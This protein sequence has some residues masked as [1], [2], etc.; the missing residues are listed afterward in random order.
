MT[1]QN[2]KDIIVF[3]DGG[4]WLNS[5]FEEAKNEENV[6]LGQDCF[7][8][9]W[10]TKYSRYVCHFF[11]GYRMQ[12]KFANS[13]I[14]RRLL[15]KMCKKIHKRYPQGAICL[16]NRT[17]YLA[18]NEY[19][20]KEMKRFN[21]DCVLVYWFTDIVSAVEASGV[22]N[23]LDICKAYYD[24]VITYEK[25]DAKKYGFHYVETPYSKKV[26]KDKISYPESDFFYIGRSKLDVDPSRFEKI[27]GLYALLKENGY[28]SYFSIYGVSEDKQVYK[29]E[30]QYNKYVK[31]GEVLKMIQN[32][33]C[34]I[35]VSQADEKG[36]TLRMFESLVYRKKLLFTNPNLKNHPYYNDTLMFYVGD[37]YNDQLVGQIKEFLE[38]P[39]VDNLEVLSKL[40]PIAFLDKISEIVQEQTRS[41]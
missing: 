39:I 26:F 33:K 16:I 23:V 18:H 35:E 13:G 15:T 19:F 4:D 7:C 31:Y 30:I 40:N 11:M 24:V 22:K 34:L 36:T 1:K 6:L 27:I 29:E 8:P 38:K 25:E 32:T 3:G 12:K 10:E 5:L 41:K 9:C 14:V 20:L 17:N 21:P 37:E 2:K 28:K